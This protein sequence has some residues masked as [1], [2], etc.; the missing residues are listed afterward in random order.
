MKI[1]LKSIKTL[2]SGAFTAEILA[3]GK[4]AGTVENRGD[5]GC[6]IYYWNTEDLRGSMI[7]ALRDYTR[8]HATGWMLENINS[9][10][11]ELE[12][13]AIEIL[14]DTARYNK[15]AKKSV[16][17]RKSAD[18]TEVYS[19]KILDGHSVES[20]HAWLATDYPE[21]V[22]WNSAIERW[23]KAAK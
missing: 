6:N 4:A 20:Q 5:G 12:D 22:V 3:D 13:W 7:D 18:A 17:F 15:L 9:E 23:V 1:A 10:Y 2:A 8:V 16:L 19:T 14:L 21:C 11:A